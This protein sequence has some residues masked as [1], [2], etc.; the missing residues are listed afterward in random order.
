MGW[1]KL[2]I[3]KVICQPYRITKKEPGLPP[4]KD[5]MLSWH[6]PTVTKLAV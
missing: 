5:R 3:K 4:K 1:K 2:D 6:D